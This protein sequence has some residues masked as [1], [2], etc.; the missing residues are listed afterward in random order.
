MYLFYRDKMTRVW[1]SENFKNQCSPSSMWVLVVELG[2]SG[3]VSKSF[4]IKHL[5][6]TKAKAEQR[7]WR[8]HRQMWRGAW[9]W[10]VYLGCTAAWVF[11]LTSSSTNCQRSDSGNVCESSTHCVLVTCDGKGS[12]AL[13]C[14]R[15]VDS[16]Q[17][18]TDWWGKERSLDRREDKTSGSAQAVNVRTGGS[19]P[20]D[21]ITSPPQNWA[22]LCTPQCLA[23]YYVLSTRTQV[24]VPAWQTLYPLNHHSNHKLF[25]F[26]IKK[27]ICFLL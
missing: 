12:A 11:F 23:A 10:F 24:L 21:L 15:W 4:S 16:L 6:P 13:G 19:K 3:L 1:R 5:P 20:R 14:G 26:H 18:P 27:H 25:S 9:L 8:Q 2:S 7:W 17:H 22:H